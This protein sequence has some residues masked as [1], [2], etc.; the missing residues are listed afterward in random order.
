MKRTVRCLSTCIASCL[1]T[2]TLVLTG[3]PALAQT[4]GGYDL[5]WNNVSG[6]G[7]TFA[8]GGGYQLGSTIGQAG[9]GKHSG[10]AYEL[11]AGFWTPPT[12]LAYVP[13]VRKP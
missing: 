3:P 2:L 13:V 11:N 10:G 6:G 7:Q 8:T 9:A 12:F 4:G 5:T 1:S